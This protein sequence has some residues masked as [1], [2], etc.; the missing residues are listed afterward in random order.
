M[1]QLTKLVSEVHSR[2]RERKAREGIEGA[3]IDPNSHEWERERRKARHMLGRIS[4]VASKVGMLEEEGEGLCS[5][6]FNSL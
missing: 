1:A 6:S 5:P 2:Y 4:A 3:D